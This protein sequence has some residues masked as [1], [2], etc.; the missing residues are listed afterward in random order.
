MKAKLVNE[1]MNF[2]REGEPMDKLGLGSPDLRKINKSWEYLNNIIQK[3]YQVP[4]LNFPELIQNTEF[5]SLMIDVVIVNHMKNKFKMRLSK[6][7]EDYLSFAYIQIDNN[8]W[9]YFV[10]SSTGK[11]IFFKLMGAPKQVRD[12]IFGS[13]GSTTLK[14]LDS[15]VTALIKKFN[16]KFE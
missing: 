11:S 16:F 13:T 6:P 3:G 2:T 5:L 12:T 7:E 15:K 8:Y 14:S 9:L 4:D 10:K 1:D